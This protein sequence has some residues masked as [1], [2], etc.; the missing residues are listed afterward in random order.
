MIRR[1]SAPPIAHH[2]ILPLAIFFVAAFVCAGCEA[3]KHT[4]DSRLKKIDLMLDKQLPA[5]T[6]RA[7]VAYFVHARGYSLENTR[8]KSLIIALVRQVDTDTLQPVTARVTFHFNSSD[9]LTTYDLQPGP[10]TPLQ[11]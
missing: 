4:S 6:T 10:E 7:Q 11:P 5:G 2:F 9:R 3:A 8:D 1:T